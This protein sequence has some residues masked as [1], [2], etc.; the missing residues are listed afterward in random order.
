MA[1]VGVKGLNI[2]SKRVA[3]G[4]MEDR[5]VG[6]RIGCPGV[7]LVVDLGE[8][9]PRQRTATENTDTENFPAHHTAVCKLQ[10]QSEMYRDYTSDNCFQT[11][12]TA[13]L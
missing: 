13:T 3:T 4:S 7:K 6:S 11:S 9:N 8:R 12:W 10:N 2:Q 1:T 5:T